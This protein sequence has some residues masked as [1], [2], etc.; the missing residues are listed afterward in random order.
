MLSLSF[1]NIFCVMYECISMLC[2][3]VFLC[4][5]LV[6]FYVMYECISMLYTGVFLCYVR[7]YFY[8][9]YECISMLCTGVFLC[10]VR[11]YFYVMYECISM[12]CTGVFLCY[13]LVYFYV[14]YECISILYTGVFSVLCIS[15]LTRTSPLAHGPCKILASY[16]ISFQACLSPAIFLQPQTPIFFRYF[17]TS[18]IHLY[19]GFPTDFFILECLAFF[20]HVITILIILL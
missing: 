3:S 13:V 5:V 7:V 17:S 15:S 19:L 2:T 9:M 6:Y 4:Y 1:K 10:Y 18:F 12:L 11:V 14:M 8:V 16:R 20:P